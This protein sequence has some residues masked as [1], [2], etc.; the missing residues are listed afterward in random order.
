PWVVG[1]TV[2]PTSVVCVPDAPAPLTVTVKV[3]VAALPDALRVSVDAPPP[4]V[5]VAGA[6][7]ALTPVGRPAADRA[8][9]WPLPEVIVAGIWVAVLPPC[10]TETLVGLALSAKSLAGAVT[11]NVTSCEWLAPPAVPV[12]VTV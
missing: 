4:E 9:A 10:A 5:T 11:L 2:R 7:E 3:P 6:N 1:V 12:T 8:T